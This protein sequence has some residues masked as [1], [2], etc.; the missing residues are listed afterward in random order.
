MR[1]II[2][3]VGII[4]III[5]SLLLVSAVVA[6]VM[7][8]AAD[9]AVPDAEAGAGAR[10]V[11]PSY[12][13]L[14]REFPSQNEPADNPTTPEKVELGRQ[15]F[16]DP[17]LSAE[18]D[19]SCATCHHPDLGFSNGEPVSNPRVGESRNVPTLWNV[20][21][22]QVLFWDGRET[23]LEA[24]A[25]VPLTHPDEMATDLDTLADELMAIPAY[26]DL[27]TAAFGDDAVTVDNVER[28]LAAFQRSL[29]SNDSPFD[30][31]AAGEF[32]ALTQQQ[33]RGLGL[34]RSGATRCFE[35][36]SNPTFALDTFR[37]IG[38]DSDDPG[39]AGVADDGA[40]GA[41]NVPTLRNIA[42]TGP[43][44][45]NGSMATLEEVLEFYAD[46]GG[47][48][49]SAENVDAFV[50][51]F[52]MSEQE[53]A[54]MLAFLYALT[55][56]SS[57]PDVPETA[58]SGLPVV[59]RLDNAQRDVAV[60]FNSAVGTGVNSA[61][62]TPQTLTVQAGETVQSVVD[63]ARP[64]DTILIPYGIYNEHVFI[65]VSNITFEGLPNDAG[66][67]PIFDGQDQLT[68]AVTAS[69]NNFSI[70]KL[71]VRNYT[72][73]GVLVEGATGVHFYDLITEN[74]GT[75]G[76]YPVK[77]T[78]VLIE[79][80]TASNVNDAAIYAG[81][82]ENV[83][84]RDSET[85]GSVIGIELENTING[86]AYNNYSHDNSLGVFVVVL[87]QLTSKVS[88]NSLIRDNL[89][90]N[91]NGENYAD[92]GMAAALVP[93]GVGVLL[94]GSDGATVT[95][96]TIRNNK[97]AGV[98]VFSLA[99][100]YDQNEIDVGPNPENNHIFN[101]T[102][103]NNGYD[104]DPSVADM[105]I[106]VGDIVWDGSGWGNRFDEPAAEPGFP[107]VLPGS[108]WP[109][110]LARIHWQA[111]QALVKIAG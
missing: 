41:F 12:S 2:K 94:L 45:H 59:A 53:K 89:I 97:T 14:Q 47:R 80:I 84:I 49:H 103:E 30:R 31:Y 44:M 4:V 91:N 66:N 38:V 7:P 50:A 65:D 16:F 99:T 90:E 72:D 42:L 54:D 57:M 74:T 36:H 111:L 10:S 13:G 82:C 22:N 9:P 83:V 101:N 24:Q 51:G 34:F 52:E 39:R 62:H 21:Y 109:D 35:C 60:Q 106:P 56:E 18:N 3:I 79:R 29:V 108:N 95:G 25:L 107:V 67:Y 26:V 33:R 64:G 8:V 110:W 81:Q 32:D 19:T 100:A 46:G 58:L 17:V 1:K 71:H 20:G 96:N 68:E 92:E 85:F 86:E 70:G 87:P 40:F 55:D 48:V 15:L 5:L 102:Y 23:S 37:I 43:Y 73:N 27:F 93:P 61:E 63:Q 11:L 6:A 104:P 98:A 78:D 88:R 69:G 105:G 28:A 75:Y 77:S 76:V